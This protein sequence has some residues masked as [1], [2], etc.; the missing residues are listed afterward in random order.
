MRDYSKSQW[1]PAPDHQSGVFLPTEGKD[2]LPHQVRIIVPPTGMSS[3][4]SVRT[5]SRCAREGSRPATCGHRRGRDTTQLP[6][7]P[8]PCTLRMRSAD[9][10]SPITRTFCHTIRCSAV[11]NL[12]PK[13]PK[14]AP[15]QLLRQP[16]GPSRSRNKESKATRAKQDGFSEAGR[17]FWLFPF[18][19]LC[20]SC[21]PASTSSS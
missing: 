10:A 17:F 14:P 4:R 20:A 18:P 12:S 16:S 9:D 21:A 3:L 11:E 15:R 13:S 7:R 1:Q 19:S 5:R 8:G 6:C 2:S